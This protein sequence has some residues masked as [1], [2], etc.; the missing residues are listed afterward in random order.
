L[1][2]RELLLKQEDMTYAMS[3]VIVYR[4]EY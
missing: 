4:I 3:P 1:F 2:E